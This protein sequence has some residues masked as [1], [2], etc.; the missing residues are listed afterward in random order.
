MYDNTRGAQIER[1]GSSPNYVYAVRNNTG[2]FPIAFVTWW[3]CCR[4]CNW[5]SNGQPSGAQIN[6]TTE[7][8]AYTITDG[9]TGGSTYIDTN[10][11]NPNTGSAPTFR[12]PTENEWYKAAYYK[13]GS[14]NAGYWTYA[15][16]SEDQTTATVGNSSIAL[17]VGTKSASYYGTYDQSGNV[18]EL[19]QPTSFT[20]WSEQH[21]ND[22]Q[23][24]LHRGGRY[25]NYGQ[26]YVVDRNSRFD[27]STGYADPTIGFRVATSSLCPPVESCC[28]D[29]RD[30]WQNASKN[31]PS[32]KLQVGVIGIIPAVPGSCNICTTANNEG[33]V[34]FMELGQSLQNFLA[35]DFGKWQWQSGFTPYCA[36]PQFNVAVSLK[37]V[38]GCSSTMQAPGFVCTNNSGCLQEDTKL[39]WTISV[40]LYT[41]GNWGGSVCSCDISVVNGKL[42]SP[43]ISITLLRSN[44]QETCIGTVRFGAALGE[45][46]VGVG[47]NNAVGGADDVCLTRIPVTKAIAYPGMPCPDDP[48]FTTRTPT[49]TPKI[50]ATP[51]LT[52]TATPNLTPTPSRMGQD[53]D[54]RV[55][56]DEWSHQIGYCGG[57]SLYPTHSGNFE[58]MPGAPHKWKS[59]EVISLGG[60]PDITETLIYECSISRMTVVEFSHTINGTKIYFPTTG[61]GPMTWNRAA[62]TVTFL[63]AFWTLEAGEAPGPQWVGIVGENCVCTQ[64]CPEGC[65]STIITLSY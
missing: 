58:R 48:R 6:T 59:I 64:S 15:T 4:F 10:V 13:G 46:L 60:C 2:N 43:T 1:T 33:L 26:A 34:P 47:G 17:N 35:A 37:C 40:L 18:W 36:D 62:R 38:S 20:Q 5:M 49:R 11:I 7:D 39:W 55:L 28:V 8:G 21:G 61:G 56:P 53:I 27:L 57:F 50:T 54:C 29:C 3:N 9:R 24:T 42:V 30:V 19:I 32:C 25:Y 22:N 14:T 63:S 65:G 41:G 51:G 44:T 31:Q 16:Q 23:I 45:T 12:M 52:P